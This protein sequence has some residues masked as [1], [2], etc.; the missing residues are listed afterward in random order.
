MLLKCEAANEGSVRA[1]APRGYK[2]SRG[3]EPRCDTVT[4]L[5]AVNTYN[6]LF[7][8]CTE[9]MKRHVSI[10]TPLCQN[11]DH[12]SAKQSTDGVVSRLPSPGR[13][14]LYPLAAEAHAHTR[15]VLPGWG[16]DGCFTLWIFCGGYVQAFECSNV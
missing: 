12:C 9:K 13:D 8:V 6:F 7:S 4:A 14:D 2:S 3:Y 11:F 16:T 5:H 1:S 10:C 15:N